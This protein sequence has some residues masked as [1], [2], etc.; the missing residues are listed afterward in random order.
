MKRGGFPKEISI[1]LLSSLLSSRNSPG[2]YGVAKLGGG[3]VYVRGSACFASSTTR[4]KRLLFL[5]FRPPSLAQF[6]YP[7]EGNGE[8]TRRWMVC[9]R[10]VHKNVVPRKKERNPFFRSCR[11]NTQPTFLLE[12][13]CHGFCAFSTTTKSR[14][15]FPMYFSFRKFAV[16]VTWRRDRRSIPC[17]KRC[18]RT[19]CA[20]RR[21]RRRKMSLPMSLSTLTWSR[22]IS[23]FSFPFT[24]KVTCCNFQKILQ[25]LSLLNEG[26]KT[27]I[28]R[29]FFESNM[30]TFDATPN[31]PLR[32][33]IET[34][35]KASG[36]Y[37]QLKVNLQNIQNHAICKSNYD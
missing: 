18:A 1:L 25:K 35:S 11:K 23:S 6:S 12:R 7:S 34:V 27:Q 36:T 5:L 20:T 17:D 33:M 30:H 16:V 24:T 22:S 28:T 26:F 8:K 3:D 29:R 4:K 2:K 14:P 37:E 10:P 19:V 15:S 13:E 9:L 31:S 32:Q 21:K